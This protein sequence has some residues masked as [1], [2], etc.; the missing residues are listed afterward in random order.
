MPALLSAPSGGMYARVYRWGI[1]R[2]FVV[3]REE[4]LIDEQC[5]LDVFGGFLLDRCVFTFRTW[6][7]AIF[8]IEDGKST[9]SRTFDTDAI[10]WLD[11]CLAR[12]SRCQV[13]NFCNFCQHFR[14][15]FVGSAENSQYLEVRSDIFA[16]S[17]VA[18]CQNWVSGQLAIGRLRFSISSSRFCGCKLNI[19]NYLI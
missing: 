11:V 6:C 3:Q 1:W 8:Q 13:Q 7:F 12:Q 10:R 5:L 18:R 4:D 17:P 16:L 19:A 9:M 2:G 14:F 15:F